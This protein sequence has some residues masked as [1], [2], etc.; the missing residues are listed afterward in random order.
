MLANTWLTPLPRIL[1]YT[2]YMLAN[3]WSPHPG[4]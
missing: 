2:K 3:T 4:S 1:T